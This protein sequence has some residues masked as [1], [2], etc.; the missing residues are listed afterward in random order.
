MTYQ[1]IHTTKADI[2]NTRCV[3]LPT[4]RLRD[5]QALLKIDGFALTANNVTYAATGDVLNYWKFF[6]TGD[7][8]LGIVPVWGFAEVVASDSPALAVG[9]RLYGF[10]P[11]ASHLIMSAE[12]RGENMVRATCPHRAELPPVYNT[13]VRANV[14]DRQEDARRAI[15][16]PLLATSYLLSDFLK[17]NDFFGAAQVIVGSASSKTGLGL[18]HYLNDLDGAPDVIG[19]TSTGNMAFVA[20][21]GTC[22]EIVSYDDLSKI[23]QRPSVYVDMAGNAD[24]RNRLHHHLGD[25]LRHSAAVGTSHWDKFRPTGKLPGARPTFFFAP[26]Q[27]E[28]R[29]ADWGPG[30]VERRIDAAW[31]R[32]ADNSEIWMKIEHSD[33][34]N[35]AQE[36]YLSIARG[37]IPPSEGQ[38]ITL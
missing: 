33:G 11:M 8:D 10:L 36:I 15:F 24:V 38:F 32:V 14:A 25:H 12:A 13:Y 6:P 26:A 28:K 4:P 2:L 34:L 16:H 3:E 37:E 21:L 18:C 29:R 19:L 5:G 30:E 17:D 31:R 35:A 27:I 1:Q 20:G 9:D 23:S 22:T 7:P